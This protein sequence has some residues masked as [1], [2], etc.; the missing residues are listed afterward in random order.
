MNQSFFLRQLDIA[1]PSQFKDKPVTVIGAGGIGAATVVALAKTGFENITVYD[2]D[3]VEEHNIPNQLLPMWVGDQD[4]LGWKKTTALFHLAHD[5]ADV[6][7]QPL[8][9]K[10]VDQPLG[11]VVISAVDSLPA[12][13]AI[14][15]RVT[16]S[17]D[18]TFFLD[19]RMA[20][21]SMD[22]YAIDMLDEEAVA[23]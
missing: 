2:F 20:I 3:T 21:T 6:A 22:L 18:T 9:E 4:T 16:G 7:I 23:S 11:E 10:F 12:R 15:E 13:R 17:M 14:W 1:D 5:L 19:G 8:H